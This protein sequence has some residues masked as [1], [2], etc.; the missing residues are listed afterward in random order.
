MLRGPEKGEQVS[1]PKI[2]DVIQLDA[3]AYNE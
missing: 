2:S 3:I 1:F